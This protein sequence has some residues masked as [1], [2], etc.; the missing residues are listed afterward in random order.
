M[1]IMKYT[2]PLVTVVK[3][4]CEGMLC[5]SQKVDIPIDGWED[6]GEESGGDAY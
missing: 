6:D 2:S 5:Y 4:D 3:I 1:E